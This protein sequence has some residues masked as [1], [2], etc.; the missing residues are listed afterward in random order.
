[1]EFKKGI[2]ETAD[3]PGTPEKIRQWLL[4]SLRGLLAISIQAADENGKRFKQINRISLQN[5]SGEMP[6][7][8]IEDICE[9]IMRVIS[10]Y[11]QERDED[12]PPIRFKLQAEIRDKNGNRHRPSVE[13][14]Y[15]PSGSADDF[16]GLGMY[17]MQDDP[18]I[19]IIQEQRHYISDLQYH[20]NE[21]HSKILEIANNNNSAMKPLMDALGHM[22]YYF[23]AG[24]QNQQ[25]ALSMIYDSKKAEAEEKGKAE[26]TKQWIDFLK[27]PAGAMAG[28]FMS[29]ASSKL[30]SRPPAPPPPNDD[31]E[32]D[33]PEAHEGARD[34]QAQTEPTVADL[35]DTL[36]DEQK[37][38]PVATFANAVAN[39]IEPH[40]WFQVT[41]I[42][43]RR[44]MKVLR[45]VMEATTD[46]ACVKGYDAFTD[47]PPTK[48]LELHGI[49][50]EE[51]KQM[52]A[53]LGELVEA[54]KSH[55][56]EA[57]GE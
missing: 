12:D 32:T 43:S 30:H 48:L 17:G 26:R 54:V 8:E 4:R 29:W 47:L 19:Q 52:L 16:E 21:S 51:Q 49:L 50:T 46:A 35:E 57:D 34:P 18:R 23:A 25:A 42:L 1:M 7:E 28:Q 56:A 11:D 36:T 31:G 9:G 39:I 3:A 22:G 13:Y 53:Q 2:D 27:K 10:Q 38:N 15:S 44:E 24:L 20:L 33:E 14:D 41:E 45:N 37:E 40:Q 55:W 5:K 6:E